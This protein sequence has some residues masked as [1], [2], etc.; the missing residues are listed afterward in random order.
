MMASKKLSSFM[1]IK[2]NTLTCILFLLIYIIT[3]LLGPGH[4]YS[5]LTFF[6]FISSL[7]Y[8]FLRKF[9]ENKNLVLLCVS[10]F[11]GLVLIEIGLRNFSTSF[12][13]YSE[14]TSNGAYQSPFKMH[15]KSW[16]FNKNINEAYTTINKEFSYEYK[17]NEYG[18]LAKNKASIDDNKYKIICLGDS[19]TE[20]VGA[21]QDSCWPALLQGKLNVAFPDSFEIINGG[22]G[23]SDIFFEWKLY[24]G[25]LHKYQPDEIIFSLN[26][27]DVT[28]IMIRG[29][30]ERFLPDSTLQFNKAPFE[31]EIYKT[32][33]L[34]RAII[35][36][37]LKHNYIFMNS[38]KQSAEAD[39]V[40]S[41]IIQ[42]LQEINQ[43]LYDKNIRMTL[44]LHPKPQEITKD[45][46]FMLDCIQT[47]K[48][49]NFTH[50]NTIDLFD[51]IKLQDKIHMNNIDDYS[52]PIDGHFNGK[53]YNVLAQEIFNSVYAEKN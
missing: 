15:S 50:A 26:T 28:D 32:S 9:I 51:Q 7:L 31:E 21:P 16:Y 53:G 27:S 37:L 24:E 30:D 23:G 42:K 45:N 22:I 41:A 4:F 10:F 44:I 11:I 13:S 19:F 25:M 29:G 14:R 33:Y 46:Y 17:T 39:K 12:I 3:N 52:W 40:C 20:G 36:G 48:A 1:S 35:N 47:I 34:A 2:R 49:C 38:S 8:L 6:A 43:T 18:I 5:A